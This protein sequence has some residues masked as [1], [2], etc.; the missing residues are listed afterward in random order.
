VYL[1]GIDGGCVAKRKLIRQNGKKRR[2][3]GPVMV[4]Q[5]PFKWRHFQAE[6]ILLCVR[7]LSTM[8]L[9]DLATGWTECIPLPEKSADAVQAALSQAHSLFPFPLLGIDTDSG[10]EFLNEQV[11]TY[12]EQEHLTFTRG[13]SGVKNDQAHVEQKNGAVVR[14]AV[15]CVRLVGVR[16]YR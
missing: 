2:K 9:T 13:R 6:I 3:R 14:E 10:S 11:I 7:C 8:T 5:H 12:C 16:A 4:E 15:G 1:S